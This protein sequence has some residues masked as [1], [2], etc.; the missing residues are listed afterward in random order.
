MVLTALGQHRQRVGDAAELG[1]PALTAPVEL[2][3]HPAVP[4]EQYPPRV[5]GGL[6]GVGHHQDGLAALV[7]LA[8]QLQQIVRG[9]G[10]EGAGGLVRQNDLRVRDEGPGHCRPLLLSAGDLIGV[11][12]QDVG[13]AQLLC[14]GLQLSLHFLVGPSRQH[15]GQEDVVPQGEDVQQVEVLEHKAQMRAAEGRQVPFPD[16]GQGLAVQKH[17][18]GSGAVQSRQNIQQ[19]GLAGAGLAHDGHILPR[20]HG[21]IHVL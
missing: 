14:Q 1:L 6:D 20:L 7:D 18:S 13:D 11:L 9:P 17:L 10:V 12:D 19:G 16:V 2:V 8:E 3:I 15:Q 5:A 4:Q 21:E